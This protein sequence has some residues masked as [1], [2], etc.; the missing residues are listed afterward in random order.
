MKTLPLSE[1]KAHLSRLVDE[2]GRRD[3]QV[4]IT[5]NGR[6]AAVLVSTDEFESWQATIEIMRDPEFLAAVRR[7]VENLESGRVMTEAEFDELF[8]RAE[9]IAR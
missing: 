2:V 6:P 7:G 8:P 4:T 3:E 9:G 5:R 1:V